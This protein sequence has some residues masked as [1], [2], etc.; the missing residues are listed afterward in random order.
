MS[1][2]SNIGCTIIGLPREDVSEVAATLLRQAV[3][4][5]EKETVL[6]EDLV[7]IGREELAK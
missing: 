5:I 3:E 2:L 4:G 1:V 7:R 6:N